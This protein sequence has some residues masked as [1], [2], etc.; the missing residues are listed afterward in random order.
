MDDDI[1]KDAK[2]FTMKTYNPRTQAIVP[3]VW[4]ILLDTKRTSKEQD[5]MQHP[6]TLNML[7]DIDFDDEQY[8]NMFFEHF[9]PSIASHAKLMDECNANIRS[10]NHLS[11][12]HGKI[13]FYDPDASDPN[14]GVKQCYLLVILW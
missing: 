9:F 7:K 4:N 13:K 3:L 14:W 10:P 6:E 5:P 8:E 11:C 12:L 1:A 2:S